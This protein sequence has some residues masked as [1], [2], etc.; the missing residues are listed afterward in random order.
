M[1]KNPVFGTVF[2]NRTYL[3]TTPESLETRKEASNFAFGQDKDSDSLHKTEKKL[4]VNNVTVVLAIAL[5]LTLAIALA[6]TVLAV[7]SYSESHAL[8]QEVETLLTNQTTTVTS[9]SIMI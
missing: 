7:L 3:P 1:E 6:S 8:K 2:H 4:R 9:E 5:I